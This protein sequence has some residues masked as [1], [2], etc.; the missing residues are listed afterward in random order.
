MSSTVSIPRDPAA[1]RPT[2][3]FIERI[4]GLGGDPPRHL[5]GEIIDA[6]IERGDIGDPGTTPGVYYLEHDIGGVVFRLVVAADDCVVL[7]GYPARVTD[8]AAD[9]GRW[10]P[11][12]LEDM[13]YHAGRD[14]RSEYDH[15]AG[16]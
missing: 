11:G 7:T 14:H 1:Y 3:H 8:R 13:D 9:T 12:E 6:C 5:S 2:I 10:T 15:D 4:K 16:P